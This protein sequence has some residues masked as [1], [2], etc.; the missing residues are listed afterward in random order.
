MCVLI[1]NTLYPGLKWCVLSTGIE[2]WNVVLGN[3]IPRH[4]MHLRRQNWVLLTLNLADSC[5]N[6]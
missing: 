2:P 6:F 5:L 3:P 1:F 4:P